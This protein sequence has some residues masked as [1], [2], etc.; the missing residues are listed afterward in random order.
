M[1]LLNFD[2]NQVTLHHFLDNY[3]MQGFILSSDRIIDPSIPSKPN[4]NLKV[5]DS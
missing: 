3:A 4:K 1:Q 5:G 2:L